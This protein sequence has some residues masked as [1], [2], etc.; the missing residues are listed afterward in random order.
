MFVD[1]GK[2]HLREWKTEASS[3]DGEERKRCLMQQSL[4]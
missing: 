3:Q 1:K 2:E 4:L